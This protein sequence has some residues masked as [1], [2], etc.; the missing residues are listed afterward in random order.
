MGKGKEEGGG[1]K[2]K[3]AGKE[4]RKEENKQSK[5]KRMLRCKEDMN[6]TR[7]EAV[8]GDLLQS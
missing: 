5:T 2:G 1:G 7:M 3:E 6:Y 4:R 8:E